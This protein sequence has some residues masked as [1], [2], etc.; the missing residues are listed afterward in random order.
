MAGRVRS[1]PPRQSQDQEEGELTPSKGELTPSK[2]TAIV[3]PSHK[4]V[5]TGPELHRDQELKP[6]TGED[7]ATSVITAAAST[8]DEGELS[9]EAEAEEQEGVIN[10]SD[11]EADTEEVAE[12]PGAHET[13]IEEAEKVV[14]ISQQSLDEL[15]EKIVECDGEIRRHKADIQ[16][17][18]TSNEQ[19]LIVVEEFERTIQQ[20]V[21]D[22]E[23]E[24]VY[25]LI[26]KET[27]QRARDEVVAD[28]D[29]VE[30]AFTDLSSKFERTRD[31]VTSFATTED[32]LKQEAEVLAGRWDD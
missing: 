6:D 4:Q 25:L 3:K 24:N 27:A 22:K 32:S 9:T 1:S 18:N 30:R 29:N 11:A 23:K 14:E 2:P 26:Q 17:V 5:D 31:V 19:M 8:R 21:K 15:S 7:T 12:L 13:V 16:R 28:L 20:I 10:H